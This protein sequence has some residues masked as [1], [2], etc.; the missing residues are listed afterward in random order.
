VDGGSAAIDSAAARPRVVNLTVHAD[1]I[2]TVLF[3]WS[4]W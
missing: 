3:R 1:L 4:R 2:G